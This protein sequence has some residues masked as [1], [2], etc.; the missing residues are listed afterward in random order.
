IRDLDLA[1][2]GYEVH[3]FDPQ[4]FLPFPNGDSIL[5]WNDAD[6][7]HRELARFSKHD[8]DAYPKYVAFWTDVMELIEAMVLEAPP[9]LSDLMAFFGGPEPEALARRALLSAAADLLAESSESA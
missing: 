1:R 4:F 9:A 3:P 8:A 2:F 5:L 6:R 7:N